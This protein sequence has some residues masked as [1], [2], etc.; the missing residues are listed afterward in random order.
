MVFRRVTPRKAAQLDP[1]HPPFAIL[2]VIFVLGSIHAM[3]PDTLQFL[4][5]LQKDMKQNKTEL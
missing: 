2:M 4:T 5:R 1:M 3:S